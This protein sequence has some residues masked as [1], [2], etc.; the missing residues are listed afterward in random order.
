MKI[1]NN[2][3]K[4]IINKT[5]KKNRSKTTSYCGLLIFDYRS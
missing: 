1:I 2:I 5:Q 3:R 4:I